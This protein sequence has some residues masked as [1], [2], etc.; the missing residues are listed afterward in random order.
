[1]LWLA[2][3]KYALFLWR[4]APA[5]AGRLWE[6]PSRYAALSPEER[7]ADADME[8]LHW[9]P[10]HCLLLPRRGA[11]DD[12]GDQL[13]GLAVSGPGASPAGQGN[14]SSPPAHS[15]SSSPRAS[16]PTTGALSGT[17]E[18]TPPSAERAPWRTPGRRSASA[19]SPSSAATGSTSFTA[20][21]VSG[22]AGSPSSHPRMQWRDIAGEGARNT[23]AWFLVRELKHPTVQ[24]A[25]RSFAEPP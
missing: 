20:S 14:A 18:A 22:A 21:P 24:T 1:M 7:P 2:E 23:V 9:V 15:E 11:V 19:P 6:L 4:P 16:S 8:S 25:I 3:S 13:Q 5:V 17:A 10:L 12:L